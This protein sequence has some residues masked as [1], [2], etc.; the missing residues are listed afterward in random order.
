MD[1]IKLARDR[2]SLKKYDGR[3]VPKDKLDLILE[4]GRLSPTA[5]NL[6]NYKIYVAES[7]QALSKVDQVTPC[8][9]GAGTVL[10]LPI[11]PIRFSL[12]QA[13]NMTLALKI[14]QLWRPTSFLAPR[15]SVWI[16][17]G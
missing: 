17:V 6:Q 13:A 4:G 8:R 14:L 9:Y 16:L 1:F 7:D 10:V 5:K 3:K 2:Y 12:I 15:P 11:M